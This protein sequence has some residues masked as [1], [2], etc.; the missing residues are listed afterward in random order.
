MFTELLAISGIAVG[1]V[2][3]CTLL[4]PQ[5]RRKKNFTQREFPIVTRIFAYMLV[6]GGMLFV[7]GLIVFFT[8]WQSLPYFIVSFMFF[9]VVFVFYM[10]DK[11][12]HALH[13]NDQLSSQP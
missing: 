12:Y 2:G 11:V 4:I 9:F 3:F 13:K 1:F 6:A 7:A 8:P 5:P 10:I